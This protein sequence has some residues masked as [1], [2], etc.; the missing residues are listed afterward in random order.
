MHE[1]MTNIPINQI[2]ILM[3]ISDEKPLVFIEK[4]E[5]HISGLTEAILY[6]K[7]HVKE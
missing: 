3:A 4:V 2:V 7:N 5:D 6:Y 1:E